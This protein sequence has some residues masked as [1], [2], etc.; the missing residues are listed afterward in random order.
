MAKK[1]ADGKKHADMIR[2]ACEKGMTA[3]PGMEWIKET[4]G[5]E[6]EKGNYA[7]TRS[8]WQK[9]AAA[10][11]S[12]AVKPVAK[13]VSSNGTAAT[14]TID[15]LVAVKELIGKVGSAERVLEL[16]EAVKVLGA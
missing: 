6:V 11:S 7:T 14:F 15:D 2:E 12:V 4:Y 5:V 13:G 16:C 9:K 10:G 3:K 1:A 8:N